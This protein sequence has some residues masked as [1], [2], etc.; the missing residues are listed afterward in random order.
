MPTEI[1]TAGLR[2]CRITIESVSPYSASRFHDEPKLSDETHLDYDVRTWRHKMTLGSD[3]KV[4]IP[5]A[6][7]K[8]AIDGAAK[9]VGGK[10]PGRGQATYSKLFTTGVLI[11]GDMA[12]NVD[13]NEVPMVRIYANL[14]GIRGGSSRGWRHFPQIAVWGGTVDAI[15]SDPDLPGAVFE[16]VVT[17]SGRC[18]G[19][20][21]WRPEKG[22]SNGRF[23]VTH[24]DWSTL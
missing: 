17:A 7:F 8:Q 21:R 9:M 3:G 20:G 12:L 19:V 15:I 16:R 24:F 10:I 13:P 23:T 14:D 11:E 18:Q 22:G 2:T 5:G 1:T 4:V 6:G